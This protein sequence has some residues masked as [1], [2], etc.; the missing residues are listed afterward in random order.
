MPKEIRM[1]LCQWHK[2]FQLHVNIQWQRDL[3]CDAPPTI[4]MSSSQ[5]SVS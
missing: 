1:A 2:G 5:T 3:H 4:W